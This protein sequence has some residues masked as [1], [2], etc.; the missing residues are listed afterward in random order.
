MNVLLTGGAGYIGSHIC[1]ELM[2]AGHT[3]AVLDDFS[4]C[5]PDAIERIAHI[6]GRS[7]GVY[8]ADV[9]DFAA[10]V[11]ALRDS[12]AQAVIHLAG[13]KGVPVSFR[14]PQAYFDTN[15]TGSATLLRAMTEC[16]VQVLV[17]SSSATVYGEPHSLPLTEEHRLAPQSPYARSKQLVEALLVEK[18]MADRAW[19]IGVLRYFNPVGAHPSGWIGERSS[20]DDTGLMPSIARVAM[21]LQSHVEV[22]GADFNTPD[23]TGVRDYLHVVDVARAHR[24]AL[25]R[26]AHAPHWL[27]ANLGRG[28]G[29]SVLQMIRAFERASGKCIPYRIGPRRAGDVGCYYADVRKAQAL[30]GW[31]ASLGLTPICEDVWRWHST[32]AMLWPQPQEPACHAKYLTKPKSTPPFATR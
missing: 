16:G 25:E 11:A 27:L 12:A 8:R 6:A 14:E 5:L 18:H 20:A 9:R 30:L 23:G 26:L 28:E 10:V 21:G 24:F 2:A 7:P 19:S 1:I 13:L 32:S 17:F 4:S 15:V 22:C 29:C 3:V 31:Q